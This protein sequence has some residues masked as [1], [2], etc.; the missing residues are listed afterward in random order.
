MFTNGQ[1]FDLRAA[2]MHIDSVRLRVR[3]LDRMAAFYQQVIGLALLEKQG[4]RAILGTGGKPL[5][6]LDGDASLAPRDPNAAGLYHTA[7]LLPERA[8]LARWLA[9]VIRNRIPLQGASD[10]IVSEAIYL[11]DPEGNGIEVYADR[12]VEGWTDPDGGIRMATDPL[13]AEDLLRQAAGREWQGFPV[14]GLVGHV[15]LQVGNTAEAE[16]FYVGT[17]GFDRMADYPGAKF[18]GSGGYHHQLAGNVWHSRGAGR[19]PEDTAGLAEVRVRLRDASLADE[20]RRR[21]AAAGIPVRE[22]DGQLTLHDP[23]G[24]AITFVQ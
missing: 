8:D 5:L 4:G 9:F 3:D 19:T 10:H 21:A 24:T 18:F 15:H 2:P 6:V 16:A 12:P 23:W 14:A 13:D 7:F 11:A 22:G 1:K 20:L 17:L